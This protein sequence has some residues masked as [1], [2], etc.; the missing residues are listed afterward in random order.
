MNGYHGTQKNPQR[1]ERSTLNGRWPRRNNFPQCNV[2]NPSALWENVQVALP[3]VRLERFW[4]WTA[5]L[6][7]DV[8]EPDPSR[9]VLLNGSG[10]K[11]LSRYFPR[12]SPGVFQ[13]FS[14]V[15]CSEGCVNQLFIYCSLLSG[16]MNICG[17]S[18]CVWGALWWWNIASA[19]QTAP[20][21]LGQ[22]GSVWSSCLFCSSAV[23][24]QLLWRRLP[25]GEQPAAAVHW[26]GPTGL[27]HQRWVTPPEQQRATMERRNSPLT[28]TKPPVEPAFG[29]ADG[30]N[31]I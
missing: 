11:G 28:G 15:L 24:H 6:V 17:S 30:L 22:A 12:F 29:S 26:E 9:M 16:T 3:S 23:P 1:N 27:L 25:D 4:F 5:L 19:V 13:V 14:Q 2:K 20:D 10:L 31:F 8:T 7:L 18:R 21:V